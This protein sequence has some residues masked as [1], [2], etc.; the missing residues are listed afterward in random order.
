MLDKQGSVLVN[1]LAVIIVLTIVGLMVMQL[2]AADVYLARANYNGANAFQLAEGG[3]H[4]GLDR[5]EADAELQ[6]GITKNF[7][8][9]IDGS[10]VQV[11]VNNE[12]LPA[13]H[14][15]I[16]S[17]A[18]TRTATRLIRAIAVHTNWGDAFPYALFVGGLDPEEELYLKNVTIE[19]PVYIAAK[20]VTLE[21][22]TFTKGANIH[23]NSDSVDIKNNCK[24][25]EKANEPPVIITCDPRTVL[26][27]PNQNHWSHTRITRELK[28]IDFPELNIA[29]LREV[30][31]FHK[32]DPA[33]SQISAAHLK[34]YNYFAG[35]IEIL[36]HNNLPDLSEITIASEGS[37]KFSVHSQMTHREM[38]MVVLA[39]GNILDV[40]KLT[41][42]ANP[43]N[44][45][46]VDL[47]LY[48]KGYIKTNQNL[49]YSSVMSQ[50]IFTSV[51][52]NQTINQ[53]DPERLPQIIR[54][55]WDIG[56]FSIVRWEN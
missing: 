52:Q 53:P 51:M 14:Y 13:R 11:E 43:G 41:P 44:S 12:G 10:T 56:F 46:Y 31:Y 8:L 17:T 47:Y 5:L 40:D 25:E 33:I 4:F 34:T 27:L 15:R 6:L 9:E 48:A 29:G 30:D 55:T 45:G 35:D 3:I 50:Y 38:V 32:W 36:V 54:D 24:L 37:V 26:K 39:E 18:S 28:E 16:T 42:G 1:V 22:V 19:G 49:T 2:V 21:G 7:I 23:F 20:K